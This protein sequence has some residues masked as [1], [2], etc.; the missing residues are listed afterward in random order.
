MNDADGSEGITK[1]CGRDCVQ[2]R[3]DRPSRRA[4]SASC[5]A[6]FEVQDAPRA[7]A[8][9]NFLAMTRLANP[10]RLNSCASFFAS[11]L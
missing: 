5:E 2:L 1:R 10:N 7:S 3:A 9:S 11:P 6:T 8:T 4:F